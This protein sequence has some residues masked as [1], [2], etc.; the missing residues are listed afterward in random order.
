MHAFF[1]ISL[2][3]YS[4]SISRRTY[5]LYWLHR[6]HFW[7]KPCYRHL[8]YP[9]DPHWWCYLRSSGRIHCKAGHHSDSCGRYIS[10]ISFSE[11]YCTDCHF[12]WWWYV[13]NTERYLVHSIGI[14]KHSCMNLCIHN[15]VYS[16]KQQ[17]YLYRVH[18]TL[19]SGHNLRPWA[20]QFFLWALP[21]SRMHA[22]HS[23]MHWKMCRVSIAR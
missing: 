5:R 10:T 20:M 1:L 14:T 15:T 18:S 8:C 6:G 3:F 23:G 19:D 9:D 17:N 16:N 4:W 21:N 2:S 22:C 7:T 11:R 13:M 12:W